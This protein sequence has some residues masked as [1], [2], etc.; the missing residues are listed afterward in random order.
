MATR[1]ALIASTS[2]LG[3]ALVTSGM[4]TLLTKSVPES[5]E[6]FQK[7]PGLAAVLV[8]AFFITSLVLQAVLSKPSTTEKCESAA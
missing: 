4:A 1:W 6:A 3:T 8:G 7:N 2:I 5:Y